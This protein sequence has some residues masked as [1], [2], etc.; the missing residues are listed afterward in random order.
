MRFNTSNKNKSRDTVNLVGGE[1]FTESDKL[2]LASIL[3]TSTLQ[4]QY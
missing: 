3:L 4:D 1:A 2:E